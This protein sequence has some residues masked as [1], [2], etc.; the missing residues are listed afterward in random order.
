MYLFAIILQHLIGELYKI[1][2]YETM[3]AIVK[4]PVARS[5]GIC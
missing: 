3:R 4:V 2:I 5:E 1:V